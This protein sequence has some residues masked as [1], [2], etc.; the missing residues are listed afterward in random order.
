MLIASLVGCGPASGPAE[1]RIRNAATYDQAMQEAQALS[2]EQIKRFAQGQSP[3]ADGV[4]DLEQADRLY[5]ALIEY[6]PAQFSLHFGGGQIAH[7]LGNHRKAEQRMRQAIVLAPKPGTVETKLIEADA[8]FG[9][10]VIELL[11][12]RLDESER[13]IREA[14]KLF[15]DNAA[16]WAALASV[17]IERR[18]IDAANAS[19]DR[20][21]KIDPA[22]PKAK[23]LKAFLA[24]R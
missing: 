21:L 16:Y 4:H 14:L 9:L 2:V 24:R 13:S 10:S 18:E 12:S 17:Q 19:L 5:D 23:Q 11:S 6:Q 7:A 1:L 20:S 22:Q 8:W 3:D 15:P